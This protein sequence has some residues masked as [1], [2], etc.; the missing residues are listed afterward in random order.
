[1]KTTVCQF[2][3]ARKLIP[4]SQAAVSSEFEYIGDRELD[5]KPPQR[6]RYSQVFRTAHFF[7]GATAVLAAHRHTQVALVLGFQ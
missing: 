1:M 2:T 3:P 6:P 7:A 4:K 5:E